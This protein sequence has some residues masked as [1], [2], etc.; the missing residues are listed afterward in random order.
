M[1]QWGKGVGFAGNPTCR[2]DLESPLKSEAQT[3]AELVYRFI[4]KASRDSLHI[5]AEKVG[6]RLH[7]RKL[8]IMVVVAF[9]QRGIERIEIGIPP[10]EVAGEFKVEARQNPEGVYRDNLH[11]LAAIC[12]GIIHVLVKGNLIGNREETESPRGRFPRRHDSSL[13]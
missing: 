4:F 13:R 11:G 1:T 5:K 2:I 12:S 8:N 10:V 3:N 9:P 6:H 7:N